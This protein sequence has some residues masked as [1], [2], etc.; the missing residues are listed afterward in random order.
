MEISITS[1]LVGT[2]LVCDEPKPSLASPTY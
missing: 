1:F 2:T